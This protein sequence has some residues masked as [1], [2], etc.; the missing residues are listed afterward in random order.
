MSRTVKDSKGLPTTPNVFDIIRKQ[1]GS[2]DILHNGE[3]AHKSIPDHWLESQLV[4]YG[5]CGE[6]Y[7]D[8]RR[9]LNKLDRVKLIYSPG[10]IK[11]STE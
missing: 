8:A 7:R 3:L 10:R 6:E 1:D 11:T 4:K 9:E 5:I 2:F